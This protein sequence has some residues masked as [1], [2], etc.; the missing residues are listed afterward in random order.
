MLL[1]RLLL[2]R[3]KKLK[4]LLLRCKSNLS[5]SVALPIWMSSVGLTGQVVEKAVWRA[6]GRARRTQPTD[7]HAAR[8]L[9][10]GP[11]PRVQRGWA[12]EHIER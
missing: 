8:V 6:C 3:T 7:S 2:L 4:L 5:G 11:L 10:R 1:L 9:R 12:T